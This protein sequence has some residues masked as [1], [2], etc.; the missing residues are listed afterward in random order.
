VCYKLQSLITEDFFLLVR[1]HQV[2][3]QVSY[4]ITLMLYHSSIIL[5]P[6]LAASHFLRPPRRLTCR[7]P[8]RYLVPAA[9]SAISDTVDIARCSRDAVNRVTLCNG[10]FEGYCALTRTVFIHNNLILL[11]AQLNTNKNIESYNIMNIQ[12]NC[13][14]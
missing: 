6:H 3:Y 10:Y 5:N 1:P 8:A 11:L 4:R 14:Y 12:L 9:G 13:Y 7:P 2:R